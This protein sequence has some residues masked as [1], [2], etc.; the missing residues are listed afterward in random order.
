M[1]V[2]LGPGQPD[3][4]EQAAALLVARMPEGW[5]TM[6][7]ARDHLRELLD[8]GAILRG[9]VHDRQL[10]GWIGGHERYTGHVYELHPLVVHADHERRGIG[11]ELV[12]DLEALVREIGIHTMFVG[13]DD[14]LGL[15]SLAGVD[16]YPDVIGHLARLE[17]LRDHPIAFYHRLGYSVV[18]VMPDANGFGRPDIYL[19]KRLLPIG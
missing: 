5:P 16:L 13:S 18:G 14:E 2:D 9:R 12:L 17:N 3:L 19:S 10:L 8:E 6:D 1:I 15:T 7:D 4:L 11:R